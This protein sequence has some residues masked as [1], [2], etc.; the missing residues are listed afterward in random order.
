[1]RID[2]EIA[3]K[4]AEWVEAGRG[5]AVWRSANLSN[6][7]GEWYTPGD[8]TDKPTWESHDKPHEVINDPSKINVV[9]YKEFK[10][11]KVSLRSASN[12]PAIKLT[13]ASSE[14]LD[15]ALKD[16]G[17]GSVYSFDYVTQE[18]VISVPDKVTPLDEWE[19]A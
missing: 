4:I 3:P 18:A 1:M 10:R 15:K 7:W 8:N 13:T 16:A 2:A 14:K 9:T 11:F 6:P 5:V 19:P 17:E 12:S